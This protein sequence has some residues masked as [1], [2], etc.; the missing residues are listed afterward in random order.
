MI[1]GANHQ[2]ESG[3]VLTADDLDEIAEEVEHSEFDIDVLKRRRRGRPMIGAGPAEVVP[4]RIDPA[5]KAAIDA[6]AAE[7]ETTTSEVIR[8]ALRRYLTVA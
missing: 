8:A 1:D 2:T 6:R 3:R 5:L 4:V 7:D